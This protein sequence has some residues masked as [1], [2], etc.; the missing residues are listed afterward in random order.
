M[1]DLTR[2]LSSF[3]TKKPASPNMCSL[4]NLKPNY[5]VLADALTIN[6]ITESIFELIT[7]IKKDFPR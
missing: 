1:L 3:H 5:H 2:F 4:L 7:V 6:T